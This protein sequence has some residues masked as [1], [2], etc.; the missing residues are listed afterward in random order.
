MAASQSPSCSSLCAVRIGHV[1]YSL[2]CLAAH[3][4][5]VVA[6]KS[7]YCR[8]LTSVYKLALWKKEREHRSLPFVY[9]C[10]V[11]KLPSWLISSWQEE[12]LHW[13]LDVGRGN[14]LPAL[15]PQ[16]EITFRGPGLIVQSLEN[17]ATRELVRNTNSQ[18]QKDLLNQKP[19][20]WHSTFALCSAYL[21]GAGN[22]PQL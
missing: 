16:Q 4:I 6:N 22:Y 21:P 12:C 17:N 5:S 3:F 11:E 2:S 15:R 8:M 7:L 19:E 13:N 14:G 1:P 9:F 10:V 20:A 18:C